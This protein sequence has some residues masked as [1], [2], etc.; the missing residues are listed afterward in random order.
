MLKCKELKISQHHRLFNLKR[1]VDM[2]KYNIKLTT[3]T[4]TL[5]MKSQNIAAEYEQQD[6]RELP[7]KDTLTHREKTIRN[8]TE[9]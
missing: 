8:Y 7:H 9:I 3:I 2:N 5:S 6:L 1:M 4:L